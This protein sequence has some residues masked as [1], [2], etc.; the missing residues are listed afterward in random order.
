MHQATS[1]ANSYYW[2]L[3]LFDKKVNSTVKI[4]LP[5]EKILKIIP[6]EEY[7]VLKALEDP[8]NRKW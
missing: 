3:Y 4:Y 6:Q 7:N 1:L 2:N 5:E 8:D